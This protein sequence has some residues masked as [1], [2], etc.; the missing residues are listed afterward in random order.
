MPIASLQN[1]QD[2]V[3]QFQVAFSATVKGVGVFA[4]QPYHCAVTMFKDDV[5]V[6]PCFGTH[7]GY[8]G[9]DQQ[10]PHFPN[11]TSLGCTKDIPSPDVPYCDNCPPGGLTLP[12]DHCKR[13]PE[14]VDVDLLLDYARAQSKAGTIDALR[15]LSGTNVY[16]YRGTKDKCYL[17][18]SVEHSKTFFT[19][20]GA[21][22][23]VNF[24]TPSAH[25]W[26]TKSY[27]TPCGGGVI[28]N[29]D[30]DGPGAALQ[31]IYSHSLKPP[32]A[33][34]PALLRQFDQRPFWSRSDNFGNKTYNET[35][36]HVTGFAPAGYVSSYRRASTSVD[37]PAAVRLPFLRSIRKI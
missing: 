19:K 14:I 9:P 37:A 10:R 36:P 34:D 7:H 13:Y 1:W 30:Y 27:G 15:N 17:A 3:V 31:H 11:M 6:P 26:P 12:Y 4:G 18:G 33:A 23:A 8:G 32:V 5:L 35:T 2:F 28:E 20:L 16:L 22:V 29:C 21:N 24:T 25:S